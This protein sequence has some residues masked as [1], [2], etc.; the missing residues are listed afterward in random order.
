MGSDSL[1]C[2]KNTAIYNR[3]G[4]E[5]SLSSSLELSPDDG[6]ECSPENEYTPLSIIQSVFFTFCVCLIEFCSIQYL[7]CH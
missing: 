3:L 2:I 6:W 7:L 1:L 5:I 4:L